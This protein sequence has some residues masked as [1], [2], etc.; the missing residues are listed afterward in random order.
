MYQVRPTLNTSVSTQ[1]TRTESITM[2]TNHASAPTKA[3]LDSG[4]GIVS[5]LQPGIWPARPFFRGQCADVRVVGP[6]P[7]VPRVEGA[8]AACPWMSA[9]CLCKQD[10]PRTL[11]LL[12]ADRIGG[13][14]DGGVS[15]GPRRQETTAVAPRVIFGRLPG[16]RRG[17]A[18]VEHSCDKG[19]A[20]AEPASAG[21]WLRADSRTRH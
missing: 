11:T 6:I 20:P 18:R 19:T 8:S 4:I 9:A 15:P 10:K 3:M 2:T 5:A 16:A 1:V 12:S 14:D 21:T 13:R 17:G 7:S